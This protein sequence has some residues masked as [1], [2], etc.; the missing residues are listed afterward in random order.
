MIY[1]VHA[2]LHIP[3]FIAYN[4]YRTS[5]PVSSAK[6]VFQIAKD[7]G[8]AFGGRLVLST[9]NAIDINNAHQNSL[10]L[11]FVTAIRETAMTSHKM[12]IQV[13]DWIEE[14]F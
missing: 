10:P 3:R 13:K 5:L 4:A 1:N 8:I 14:N 11:S 9:V 6:K 2:L 12:Y 7:G